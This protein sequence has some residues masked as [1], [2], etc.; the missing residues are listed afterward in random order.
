MTVVMLTCIAVVGLTVAAFAIYDLTTFRDNMVR[1]LRTLAQVIAD[2]S[3]AALAFGNEKDAR[4]TLSTLRNEPQVV[5][6]ALYD[7][8]GKLFVA[9]PDQEAATAAPP[10]HG[11]PEYHFERGR[12]ILWT[13]V[14]QGSTQLGTLCI[15]EDLRQFY[16][17]LEIYSA[18][19]ALIVLA[20]IIAALVIGH[21]L[22]R[23]ISDPIV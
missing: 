12:L 3:T 18:V 17:R 19:S 15:T 22:Q 5:A 14:Y 9:Y 20:S 16:K 6:A 10:G 7:N 4:E 23:R 11:R 2:N 21:R 8:Q 1:N 13:P